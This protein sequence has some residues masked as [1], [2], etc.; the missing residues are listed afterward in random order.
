MAFA[1]LM[2]NPAL[3]AAGQTLER[4]RET[5]KLRL[6]H[7]A[8]AEPFSYQSESGGGAG[9][10]MVL[11]RKVAD[12]IKAELSLSELAV[13]TVLVGNHE[14]F[15][16]VKQGRI[17]L[18]CGAATVTLSRRAD[19]SFSIPVF[20]GGIAALVRKDA[21]A[22]LR[23]SLIGEEPQFRSREALGQGLQNR[24]LTVRL[25]TTA[26]KWIDGELKALGVTAKVAPVGFHADGIKAIAAGD[27]EVLFGDRAILLDEVKRSP[28]GADLTILRRYFTYEAISL[29]LER[30][31]EDFRLLVD[32]TLS[33]L[34]RSGE[35]NEI[36]ESF[37]GESSALA[38]GLFSRAALPE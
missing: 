8:D 24:T 33:R 11:C 23:A 34:Y 16:A 20:L 27:A 30:G 22:R 5:G 25:G 29:A 18:L 7:R 6:G 19:V 37:F 21:P 4:V 26:E 15:L 38:L 14:R 13:E 32:R 10:S 9:Y 35:I 36:Y 1:V 2:L 31:D 3:P 17:D 28:R 12:A